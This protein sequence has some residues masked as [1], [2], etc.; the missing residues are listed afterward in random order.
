VTDSDAHRGSDAPIATFSDYDGLRK[1]LSAVR[2]H[3]NI[4]LED[5]DTFGGGPSGGF[6]KI[7]GPRAVRRLGLQ[8][9]GWALGGL[10]VRCIIVDD[11]EAWERIS[12]RR[13]FKLRD[14]SHLASV[15]KMHA[16]AVVIT[17]SRKEMAAMSRKGGIASWAKLTP[18]QRAKR[19]RKMSN[20]R[21]R[22]T[23]K[24][25]RKRA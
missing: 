7:L 6:G 5:L 1:A 12:R 8:S 22:K 19:A 24:R 2:E 4:S 21:W 17:R 10:G 13:D 25:L 15:T 23:K 14:P 11:P 9:L 3:R 18:K 16:I 20:A